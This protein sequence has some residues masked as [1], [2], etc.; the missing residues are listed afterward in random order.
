MGDDFVHTIIESTVN[1]ALEQLRN[2]VQCDCGE[3]L[4]LIKH[5]MR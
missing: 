1:K 4:Q 2:V 3:C 5:S